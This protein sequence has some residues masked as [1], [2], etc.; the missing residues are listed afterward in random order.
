[1]IYGLIVGSF[2]FAWFCIV[3]TVGVRKFSSR[4]D[5]ITGSAGHF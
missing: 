1:M 4:R 5:F 2:A 3:I